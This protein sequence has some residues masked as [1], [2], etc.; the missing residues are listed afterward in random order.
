MLI[1]L[2]M[3]LL[4]IAVIAY[5]TVRTLNRAEKSQIYEKARNM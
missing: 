3:D 1:R 4:G 2:A 5:F